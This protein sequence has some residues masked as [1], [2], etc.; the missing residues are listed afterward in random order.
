[1]ESVKRSFGFF[2]VAM[3][4]AVAVQALASES[5]DPELSGTVWLSPLHRGAAFRMIDGDPPK[6]PIAYFLPLLLVP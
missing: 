4:A 2:L 5:Y 6:M 3:A 1:M